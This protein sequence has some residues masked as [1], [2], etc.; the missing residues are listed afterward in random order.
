MTQSQWTAG[1]TAIAADEPNPAVQRN[2]FQ[3]LAALYQDMVDFGFN[4]ALGSY[5]IILSYLE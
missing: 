3:Y 1:L 2:M 5:A 4:V